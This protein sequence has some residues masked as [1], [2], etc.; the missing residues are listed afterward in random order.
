MKNTGRAALRNSIE[1]KKKT[2]PKYFDGVHSASMWYI[3]CIFL[4]L[5]NADVPSV[6]NRLFLVRQFSKW[7]SPR[8]SV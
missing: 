6:D 5:C 4:V 1:Y 3:A 7:K 2:K 8:R